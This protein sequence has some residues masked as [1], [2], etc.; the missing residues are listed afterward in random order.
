MKALKV[1]FFSV[2]AMTIASIS[3]AD[4]IVIKTEIDET[5]KMDIQPE[6]SFLNV[7]ESI[8]LCFDS[9]QSDTPDTVV[10][11]SLL[12]ESALKKFTMDVFVAGS[13]VSK[14]VAKQSKNTPRN[15]WNPVTPEEKKD[16]SLILKTLAT[17][18]PI[19][20]LGHKKKLENAGDRVDHLHP[21]KWL[22]CILTDEELKVYVHTLEDQR[23]MAWKGFLNGTTKSLEQESSLGNL[24]PEYINDF[25][26]QLKIDPNAIIPALKDR[27]W[28]K[29]VEIVIDIVPWEGGSDRYGQN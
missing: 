27:R 22:M 5:L 7:L 1:L 2:I 12:T 21:F 26:A 11:D 20:L 29:F 13:K 18:H 25:S 3:F 6:D 23:G 8:N 9:Y 16:V 14:V 15:Y 24:K 4:E 17:V 10:E 28:E 19:K